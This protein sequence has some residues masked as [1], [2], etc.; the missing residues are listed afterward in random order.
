MSTM[1]IVFAQDETGTTTR[2]IRVV[3]TFDPAGL[4]PAEV[5]SALDD[6]SPLFEGE[7]PPGAVVRMVPQGAHPGDVL[8]VDAS[9]RLEAPVYE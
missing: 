5:A 4:S 3:D 2:V 9:V 7:P 1:D 8:H 6:C